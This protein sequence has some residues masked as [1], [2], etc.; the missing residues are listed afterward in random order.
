MRSRIRPYLGY[1]IGIDMCYHVRPYLGYGVDMR[2]LTM[3]GTWHWYLIVCMKIPSIHSI[4]SGST[5]S[6]RVDQR[7]D[8]Y[9]QASSGIEGCR[10]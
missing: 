2:F 7:N 5:S 6:L 3:F 9:R 1:G 8:K 10:S 4:P